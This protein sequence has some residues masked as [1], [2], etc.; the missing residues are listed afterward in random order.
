MT[1]IDLPP[2]GDEPNYEGLPIVEQIRLLQEWAPL[3]GFGQRFLAAADAY[4]RTLIVTEAAA[5]LAKKTGTKLDDGLVL[6]VAAML[7][8]AE[9]EAFVKWLVSAAEG[10]P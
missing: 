3:I 10:N 5:W 1:D 6:H 7:R 2:P 8:T 4:A 9:G